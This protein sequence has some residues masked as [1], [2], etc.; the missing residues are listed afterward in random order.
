VEQRLR[1]IN[2]L[3]GLVTPGDINPPALAQA[4]FQLAGL[5]VPVTGPAG[6]VT[7]DALLFHP[8]SAHL[9]LCEVKSGANVE[10]DQARR[11]AGVDVG[12]VVQAGHVTLPRRGPL[13]AEVVYVCI[14]D[15]VDRVRRGL[16]VSGVAFGMLAVHENKI[17][18]ENEHH[19]GGLLRGVFAEGPTP[20]NGPP[21][22]L[23]PFD[24][25]SPLDVIEPYV[26]AQLVSALAN[27][28]PQLT[29]AA[30]TELAAPYYGLY[31]RAARNQLARRVGEAA[32]RIAASDSARF[33]FQPPTANRDGLVRL[34][35]T[36]EDH[37]TRG[38][39]PAYQ[40]L[41]RGAPRRRRPVEVDP[42]QLD[43]LREL[44]Q[45]EDG[46]DVSD[47]DTAWDDD[48]GATP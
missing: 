31:G 34:L 48:K 12:A 3:I 6:T 7:V 37:D 18:L 16:Q 36:P 42:S 2:A 8:A 14:C 21:P 30:L 29:V 27:R 5:E 9:L 1:P 38:R 45:V 28:L 13:T 25:D 23:V 44:D 32:R 17:T 33:A 35:R 22:R 46:D 4:G 11:Y 41:A 40:A 24:H 26:R 19:A 39:T 47:E 15:H 10:A 20:L 43:L